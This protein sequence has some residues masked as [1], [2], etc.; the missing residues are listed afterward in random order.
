[1][2]DHPFQV[3]TFFLQTCSKFSFFQ[4]L[5]PHGHPRGPRDCSFR[6]TLP[7]PLALAGE[8]G[9]PIPGPPGSAA[10]A[11]RS[12]LWRRWDPRR[13]GPPGAGQA[14]RAPRERP[15]R[16]RSDVSRASALPVTGSQVQGQ[17]VTARGPRG[18]RAAYTAT[19]RPWAR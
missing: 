2:S 7:L 18:D 8:L 14:Q 17:R 15:E 12:G 4:N 16:R 11:P 1:M 3:P 6:G 5:K 9:L 10:P 19:E 13:V